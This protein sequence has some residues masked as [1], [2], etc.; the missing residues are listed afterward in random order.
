MVRLQSF[1]YKPRFNLLAWD[2]HSSLFRCSIDGKFYSIKKR[3]TAMK[4][5]LQ[6]RHHQK[7]FTFKVAAQS[8]LALKEKKVLQ[9]S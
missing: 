8:R 4:K 2:K 7:K 9:D 3:F 5:V 6:L 1:T